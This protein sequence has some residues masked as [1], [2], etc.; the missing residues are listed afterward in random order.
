M[1]LYSHPQDNI[2]DR[3]II[4][5]F[6]FILPIIF[7]II[8][9][10]IGIVHLFS[11][12]DLLM[13]FVQRHITIWSWRFIELSAAIVLCIGWLALIN[14]LQHLY[15]KDLKVSWLPKRFLIVLGVQLVLYGGTVLL[16]HLG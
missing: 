3:M 12:R 6:R 13:L 8:H 2:E 11:L 7:L 1:M 15:E 5:I 10:G 14:I 9:G 16:L 4:K